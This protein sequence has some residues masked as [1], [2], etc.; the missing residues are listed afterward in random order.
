MNRGNDILIKTTAHVKKKKGKKKNSIVDRGVSFIRNTFSRN[1][2]PLQRRRRMDA[3]LHVKVKF[4]EERGGETYARRR[5]RKLA[6]FDLFT[7]YVS[8][9]FCAI[10]RSPGGWLPPCKHL[11]DYPAWWRQSNNRGDPCEQSCRI[12]KSV[13]TKCKFSLKCQN[14]NDEVDGNISQCCVLLILFKYDGPSFHIR[15][16]QTQLRTVII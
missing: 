6:C 15:D 11:C 7:T 1:P 2:R 12:A 10:K 9:C 13:I 8:V 14:Y 16:I 4:E 5:R 3:C